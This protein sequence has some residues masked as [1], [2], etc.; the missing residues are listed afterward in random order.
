MP[1]NGEQQPGGR[2]EYKVYRSRRGILSRLRSPDLAG[3]R[4]RA[5]KEGKDAE[6]ER[7][8]GPRRKPLEEVR[9][10]WWHWLLYAAG[11]WVLI[12]FAAFALSSQL[13]KMKLD[14]GAKDVLGGNPFLLAD[15]QTI[16]VI[17][18]DARESGSLEPGAET[19][20]RCL[21]QQ[22]KGEPPH[23]GCP[24]FRADTLM[25][26]RAG[27]ATFRKLS[28]PR[29]V[30]AEIPGQF[31]QK[32]NA[33]YAFG[34]A[35][36][37]I[38][39]VEQFL[40]I[41]IDQVVIVDF[42]G[43]KDFIDAI[44]GVEVDVDKKVCAEIN[45]GAGGGQGGFTLRLGKGE[46]TLNGEKALIFARTRKN[47]CDPSY[48]DRD[49]AEAQQK[50]LDGI[51]GRLTSPLRLPYNFIK[52]PIIGWTA[53]KAIVSNMGALTMPQLILSSVFGSS[54]T[55]VLCGNKSVCGVG[56]GSSIEVPDS[57]RRRAVDKLLNG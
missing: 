39:T 22:E 24:G 6:R 54:S 8:L 43:F 23:D 44:G 10:R 51:K 3:L 17:G 7:R 56:P 30:F 35:K 52:G 18:T 48:D 15:P 21:D 12:S 20:E 36:L 37:Q 40:G 47:D 32:I 45:G 9:R 34:G 25:L 55:D 33:G 19:R 5:R 27:R 57:E 41:E 26:V 13:Q 4:E 2:P 29:D 49:R 1:D 16:L 42:D 28:I 50:I 31:P 46:H 11:A 14:D 53:P 38:E